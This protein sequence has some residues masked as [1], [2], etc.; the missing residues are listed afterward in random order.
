[1]FLYEWILSVFQDVYFAPELFSTLEAYIT[2][3]SFVHI[4][5]LKLLKV[6]FLVILTSD[7]DFNSPLNDSVINSLNRLLP[8]SLLVL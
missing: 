7:T 3:H 5:D 1:M 6:E 2:F 4:L 8:L